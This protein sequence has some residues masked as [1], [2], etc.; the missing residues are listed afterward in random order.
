MNT[1]ECEYFE[2]LL[3]SRLD[4]ELPN[5][6]KQELDNHLADCRACREFDADLIEQRRILRSLPDVVVPEGWQSASVRPKWWRSRLSVPFPVAAAI[7]LV[8]IGGWITALRSPGETSVDVP[9]TPIMVR[10]VEIVR[11]PAVEA[12]RV[13]ADDMKKGNK[14]EVL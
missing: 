14:E 4:E 1:K 11:V 7:A 3:S 5:A 8:A 2:R 13:D 6:Q 12:I 9:E 10:S